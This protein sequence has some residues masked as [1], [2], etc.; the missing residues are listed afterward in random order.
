MSCPL[1]DN[2]QMNITLHAFLIDKALLSQWCLRGD[3]HLVPWLNKPIQTQLD[4]EQGAFTIKPAAHTTTTK[5]ILNPQPLNLDGPAIWRRMVYIPSYGN[6]AALKWEVNHR[7]IRAIRGGLGMFNSIE[8][9]GSLDEHEHRLTF[10]LKDG[11]D[12]QWPPIG[13]LLREGMRAG[14][15]GQITYNHVK[16]C[17]GECA[18]NRIFYL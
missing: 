4:L 18:A 13:A 17:L 15:M 7:M 3:F 12:S 2:A 9:K 6:E 1:F 14:V 5:S 11:L 8:I 10:F 16:C